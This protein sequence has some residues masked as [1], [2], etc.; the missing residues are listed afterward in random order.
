MGGQLNSQITF[1][2]TKRVLG[3]M[4]LP[5]VST[6]LGGQLNSQITCRVTK[7]VLFLPLATNSHAECISP[8]SCRSQR[9]DDRSLFYASIHW[10]EPIHHSMT[11]IHTLGDHIAGSITMIMISPRFQPILATASNSGH[12]LVA[13]YNHSY[14]TAHMLPRNRPHPL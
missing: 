9:V 2:L 11:C 3:E 4:V 13:G 12:P 5:K 7:R 6:A 10:D 14:W 1:R 8:A